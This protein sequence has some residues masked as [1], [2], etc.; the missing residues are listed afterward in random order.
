MIDFKVSTWFVMLQASF[1]SFFA[2]H[3]GHS[4]SWWLLSKLSAK[5]ANLQNKMKFSRF[6]KLGRSALM[7]KFTESFKTF[8]IFNY[9]KIGLP[10]WNFI[11]FDNF[12]KTNSRSEIKTVEFK[13]FSFWRKT[14]KL[15][16]NLKNLESKNCEKWLKFKNLAFLLSSLA[17]NFSKLIVL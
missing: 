17:S 13:F 1:D 8:K 4:I 9:N 6:D 3:F 7:N 15:R 5:V 16:K 14:K 2:Q 12:F 10:V 11:S